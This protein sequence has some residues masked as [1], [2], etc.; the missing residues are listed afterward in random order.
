LGVRNVPSKVLSELLFLIIARGVH[1]LSHSL[2][3]DGLHIN[4]LDLVQLLL[5][6]GNWVHDIECY[7]LLSVKEQAPEVA[8]ARASM[9]NN[10]FLKDRT[11]EVRVVSRAH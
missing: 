4:C 10:N 8:L 6:V 3:I 5:L 11:R 7:I 9:K 1:T 2:V